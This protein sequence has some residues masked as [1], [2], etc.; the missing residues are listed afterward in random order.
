LNPAISTELFKLRTIRAPWAVAAVPGVLAAAILALNA[1]LL[2]RPGQP[3][4]VPAVLGD[5][6]RAPGRL[7][8]AA[9]LLLGLLMSTAE[10]RHSTALTTRLGQPR[11]A[12][13]VLAK[14]AAAALA[15]A[16]VG[17]AVELVTVG[18]GAVMLSV[19]GAAVEPAAHGVP[20][21]V[22]GI[23]LV[24]ALHGIAGVGIGEALRNPALAVGVVFGWAFVVEGVLP[25]VLRDPDAARWLPT[26]AIRSALSIGATHEETLLVPW[27]G[28]L[29]LTAYAGGLLLPGLV[30]AARSDA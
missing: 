26:G 27:A 20:A 5:L 1:A 8:G 19:R 10:Y 17:L 6:A 7:A 25:V 28:L 9:A 21:A 4:L 13:L 14:A 30:R 22:A 12:G 11:P 29:V 16:A 2:G 24:A 23:V 18:G 15:G 3:E